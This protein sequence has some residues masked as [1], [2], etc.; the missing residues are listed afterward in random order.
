MSEL[1][2]VTKTLCCSDGDGHPGLPSI[3]PCRLPLFTASQMSGGPSAVIPTGWYSLNTLHVSELLCCLEGGKKLKK[4]FGRE[5]KG[6]CGGWKVVESGEGEQKVMSERPGLV[7]AG[8][9]VWTFSRAA[10]KKLD[11]C[12]PTRPLGSPPTYFPRR[13]LCFHIF[14]GFFFTP[15]R[16]NAAASKGCSPPLPEKPRPEWGS[17]VS[18]KNR[19]GWGAGG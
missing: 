16:P 10:L 4:S 2:A 6:T 5:A 19:L 1:S 12:P 18:Q 8:P 3:P 13:F 14:Q 11:P 9:S 17:C 7:S 15:H